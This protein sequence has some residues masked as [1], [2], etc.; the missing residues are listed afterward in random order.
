MCSRAAQTACSCAHAPSGN[1][2]PA[3]IVD[4]G[5][6]A[7]GRK[8]PTGRAAA[9]PAVLLAGPVEA[10]AAATGAAHTAGRVL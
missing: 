5:Q 1:A 9:G 7:A 6:C 8:R 10:A 2:R 3:F 4:A